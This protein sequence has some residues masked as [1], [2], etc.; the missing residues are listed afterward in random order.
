MILWVG[1]LGL[2]FG[3]FT[4]CPTDMMHLLYFIGY[5]FLAHF[6]GPSTKFGHSIPR[7]LDLD[8]LSL[9]QP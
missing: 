1:T 7:P 5:V 2:T 9:K 6:F 3:G 4:L 8:N